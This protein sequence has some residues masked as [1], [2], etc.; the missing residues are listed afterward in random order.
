MNSA[1]VRFAAAASAA[2]ALAELLDQ[3]GV[4]VDRALDDVALGGR[5]PL[6]AAVD[7]DL[8][9]GLDLGGVGRR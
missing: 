5:H 2:L 8:G 9:V 7:A 4:L 3:R 6:E 1:R